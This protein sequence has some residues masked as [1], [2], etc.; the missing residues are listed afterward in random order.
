MIA[1]ATEIDSNGWSCYHELVLVVPR[2]S[3]EMLYFIEVGR[4][5]LL[6]AYSM[7]LW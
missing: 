6:P 2:R 3:L 4:E 5:A 7:R 1:P